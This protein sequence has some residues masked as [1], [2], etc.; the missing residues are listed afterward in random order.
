LLVGR[1]D[2]AG[3]FFNRDPVKIFNRIFLKKQ[4]MIFVNPGRYSVSGGAL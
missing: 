3:N 2:R 4:V 1:T